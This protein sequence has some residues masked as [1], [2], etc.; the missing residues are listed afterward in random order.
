M[1]PLTFNAAALT[2]NEWETW[3]LVQA[4]VVL[5]AIG[6]LSVLEYSNP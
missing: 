4:K 1:D 2:F 6:Y 5:F 3:P